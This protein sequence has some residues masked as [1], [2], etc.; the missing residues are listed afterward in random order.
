MY[1]YYLEEGFPFSAGKLEKLKCFLDTCG[2]DYDGQISYSVMA[3]SLD[4]K[5][6]AAGSCCQNVLKCL[7]VSEACQGQGFLN[8]I[9]AKL[10][11]NAHTQGYSHL[12]LF[13]KPVYT[14]IFKELGFYSIINTGKIEFMENIPGGI[15]AYLEEEQAKCPPL[16]DGICAG[17][18][19]MNANPFTLG[20][21][22]LIEQARKSC[23]RLHVFVLSE[24][25]PPFPAA[26]RLALVRENCCGL[27]QVYVHGG[28]EYLISHTTFPDYFMKDK[29]A[30]FTANGELD[31]LLFSVYFKEAFHISKR[32]VGEEPFC[33]VTRAYNQQM[34]EILPSHGIQVCVL[35]RYAV[36]GVPVSAT[37]VRQH[38]FQRDL[39]SIAPLV[40]EPTFNYLKR[41]MNL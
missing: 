23:D 8:I 3:C 36:Q 6:L 40:P 9:M 5:V 13:T 7:A 19:V 29:H 17:A 39:D 25:T 10:I 2:L 16:T 22:H 37:R 28:S 30:A 4:G 24:D 12:F 31:L 15:H 33:P 11:S 41:R 27:P 32:F 1:N 34:R 38:Y 21:L 20:H 18:I 14:D 35:P 26:D